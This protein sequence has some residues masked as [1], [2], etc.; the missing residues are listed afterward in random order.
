MVQTPAGPQDQALPKG[1]YKEYPNHVRTRDGQ[2]HAYAPV[3]Q[4]QAEMQRL[5]DELDSTDFIEAHPVLQASYA[6]YAF[7]AIHPFAD[8]N[9]RVARALASAYTYRSASVPLLV[10]AHQRDMYFGALAAA[11][12]G[13]ADSFVEFTAVVIREA[14]GLV[15]ETLKT[16]RAPQPEDV[17]EAFR[18]L[19]VV[20]GELSHQQLDRIANEFVNDVFVEIA[21]EQRNALTLPDGIAIEVVPS[22]GGVQSQP[23]DGFRSVVHSGPRSVQLGFRSMPPGG[24]THRES[25]DVFVA[26]GPD[27]VATLLVRSAGRPDEK[28]GLSLADLQPQLSSAARHRLSSFVRRQ[29]GTGLDVLYAKAKKSLRSSGY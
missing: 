13:S 8:G 18:E 21:N 25:T 26:T 1:K 16:A 20:Q 4:T 22:S 3:D 7:V 15:V 11:D 28:L 14:V 2:V 9:G 23:P 24:A 17:L 12:S 6:H 10:Q 5:L 27:S 29:L 19:F